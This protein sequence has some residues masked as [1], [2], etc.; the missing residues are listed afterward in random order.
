MTTVQNVLGTRLVNRVLEPIWNSAHIS[1]VDI[2]WD[3]SLALEGRAGYYDD[4]GALKDMLQNHLL[5]VLWLVAMEP[6]ISLGDRDLR[7]GKD[8]VL[9]SVR[10]LSS[11][12]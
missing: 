12:A 2:I 9:R 5:Q 7:N 6:P 1:K 11:E 10:I 3:E 8:D 4:V